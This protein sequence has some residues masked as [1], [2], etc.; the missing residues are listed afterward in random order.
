MISPVPCLNQPPA[1]WK[2]KEIRATG[3]WIQEFIIARIPC[4]IARSLVLTESKEANARQDASIKAPQTPAI[5]RISL[6][7]QSTLFMI[8]SGHSV[9]CYSTVPRSLNDGIHT[10][11]YTLGLVRGAVGPDEGLGDV[12]TS[13][14]VNHLL[15]R[16]RRYAWFSRAVQIGTT[17]LLILQ[18]P[19][20]N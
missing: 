12:G 11:Y 10:Y 1:I 7:C 20:M 19:V 18:V 14:S 16:A 4:R 6:S 9:P 15:K 17:A 3:L 5:R 8:T 13:A 2:A